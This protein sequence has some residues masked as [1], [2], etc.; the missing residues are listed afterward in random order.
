MELKIGINKEG[1]DSSASELDKIL[2]DEFVLYIKTRN[3]H[4]NIEGNNFYPL[5]KFFAEQYDQID[6]IMDDVAERIRSLGFYAPATLNQ[7]LSQTRLE[8]MEHYQDKIK[9]LLESHELLITHMRNGVDRLAT[10]YQDFGT[11]DFIT[12]LIEIHEKMAWM[13]RAHLK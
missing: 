10:K 5:H 11:S 4:W 1:L 7:Y 3:A 8:E 6:E 9:D 2:A 13:L 12:G